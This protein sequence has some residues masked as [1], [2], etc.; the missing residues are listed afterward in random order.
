MKPFFPPPPQFYFKDREVV[1]ERGRRRKRERERERE[2][3]RDRDR[4]SQAGS[5][6]STKPRVG[7]DPLIP[8]S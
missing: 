1:G 2:E 6:F 3:E 8:G 7:L 5:T 4:E